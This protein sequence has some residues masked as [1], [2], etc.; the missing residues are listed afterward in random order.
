MHPYETSFRSA[1]RTMTSHHNPKK[2]QTVVWECLE[3]DK[4]QDRGQL[5][6]IS[7]V[8]FIVEELK[9][10][11]LK[12][13]ELHTG[14]QGRW[15]AAKI[16]KKNGDL[17]LL[18]LRFMDWHVQS[19]ENYPLLNE[20][21]DGYHALE[22][23]WNIDQIEMWLEDKK[24]IRNGASAEEVLKTF[25]N[26]FHYGLE[27]YPQKLDDNLWHI[28]ELLDYVTGVRCPNCCHAALDENDYDGDWW[29]R[30]D[31]VVVDKLRWNEHDYDLNDMQ[32]LVTQMQQDFAARQQNLSYLSDLTPEHVTLTDESGNLI[33][34]SDGN[35]LYH[36]P[37]CQTVMEN[38][39]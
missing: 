6:E 31:V 8:D 33:Y 11:K 36:C 35:D 37:K 17:N 26:T 1:I 3:Y 38:L 15:I 28:C 5:I 7:N 39:E 23:Q 10:L 24:H 21:T 27:D 34:V 29:L 2:G 13:W 30:E 4:Y 22:N 14:R 19:T 20:T 12:G 9:R 32:A 16:F 25:F 18:G